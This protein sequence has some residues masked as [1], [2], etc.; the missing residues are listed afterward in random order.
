[1]EP[2]FNDPS[3]TGEGPDYY[4]GH[5]NPVE[6]RGGAMNPVMQ[7]AGIRRAAQDRKAYFE[8]QLQEAINSK[9]GVPLDTPLT[10]DDY[11]FCD[12]ILRETKD[13]YDSVKEVAHMELRN[14]GDTPVVQVREQPKP[15]GREVEV[16]AP[17]EDHM[18]AARTAKAEFDKPMP[19]GASFA[20]LLGVPESQRSLS[21]GRHLRGM[22]TGDW[23]GAEAEQ[24]YQARAMS[25]AT[26]GAGGALLPVV[27]SAQVVDLARVQTQ[28]LNAGGQ[29][30]P[31]SA[32]Q[33]IMPKWTGD[34]TVA[35]R[36]EN[37]A[38][39]T[40]DGTVDKITFTAQSLAGYTTLSREIIEDTDLSDLL[41]NAYA[42]AVAIAWDNAALFGTGTAPQPLGLKNNANITDNSA[43]VTNGQTPSWDNLIDAVG[44]V[45]GRNENVSA[46]VYHPRNELALGKAKDSQQRYIDV[47]RY[48][49]DVPRLATGTIP[50]NETEGTST[51]VCN[52]MFVADWSQLYIGIRTNFSVDVH[53]SPAA[54]NGQVLMVAWMRMDVQIG[55]PSAFAV[56]KGLKA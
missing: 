2:D 1:M 51:N 37:G 29:I 55:R 19:K 24:A 14:A 28:V 10:D 13:E 41:A 32:R 49:A 17:V 27:Y 36:S 34:P 56:R 50:V 16:N 53:T 11:R 12:Q 42:K 48:I 4:E 18:I 40:G 39:A 47:P 20:D 52:S 35:F 5:S 31:L 25:G 7:K 23:R 43:I 30:V 38:V 21:L 44:S 8:R 54:T 22:L 6:T 15:E 9:R 3:W 26:A 33:V 45:R 46:I